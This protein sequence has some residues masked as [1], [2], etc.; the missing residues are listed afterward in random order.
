MSV[1]QYTPEDYCI[2]LKMSARNHILLGSRHERGV[3]EST[4]EL[5]FASSN[6][7]DFDVI[8]DLVFFTEPLSSQDKVD[9][10]Y[11]CAIYSGVNN[12]LIVIDDLTCFL[13]ER[14]EIPPNV[15]ISENEDT[16]RYVNEELTRLTVGG[17]LIPNFEDVRNYLLQHHDTLDALVSIV[18]L[19]IEHFDR[20]SQFSLEVYEDPEDED[21]Y[22]SIYVRQVN[23]DERIIERLDAIRPLCNEFLAGRSGWVIVTTDFDVP[24]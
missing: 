6:E 17:L 21:R 12:N 20:D 15:V 7:V 19:V 23:Y 13:F 2:Y 1:I 11:D 8:E 16:L 14:G 5:L 4:P 3:F 10:L 9:R 18:N 24:R 22:L